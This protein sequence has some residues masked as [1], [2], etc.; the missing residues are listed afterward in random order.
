MAN[1]YWV[2]G[3]GTW[4]TT[5][6]TNWST[7][8]GGSGGASVPTAADSVF[9]D[10]AGTYTVTCS[11]A[12]KCL[13]FTVSAGSVTFSTGT[14]PAFNI[15][16]SLSF[17]LTTIWS[18]TGAITF[19]ATTTGKTITTNGVAFGSTTQLFFAGTGGYWTL[20][21]AITATS[22]TIS[23]SDGTFD[24]SASNYS[25]TAG[26]LYMSGGVTKLNASTITVSQAIPVN[27]TGGTLNAGTSSISCSST[28]AQFNGGGATFYNVAFT[29]TAALARTITGANT[30][31]NLS[32]T[33]KTSAGVSNI[34]IYDNQTINGTLTLSAG[35]NATARTFLLSDTFGTTRTLTCA[36]FSATDIDFQDITIAGAAAPASGTRLGD[37]KGNSGITFPAPKTVYKVSGTAW[38]T[39]SSWATS[40][41]GTGATNN[42]PLAQDTA[43]IDNFFPATGATFSVGTVTYAFGTVDLSSRTNAMTFAFG[44]NVSIYGNLISGTG[45]T[46]SGGVQLIFSGRNNQYITS[47]G[48]THGIY[49]TVNTITGTVSL[50]DALSLSSGGG[51]TGTIYLISGTFDAAGYNVTATSAS[52]QIQLNGSTTRSIN[53]GSGTWTIAGSGNPWLASVPTA[54]SVSGTGIISF[55]SSSAK[56]FQGGSV[57]YSGITIDQNGS[58][59]LTINGSNTLKDVTNTYSATGATTIKF[60]ALTT[61]TFSQFTATGASG[62]VLTLDSTTTT[63]A[64]LQKGSTWYMGANSTNVSNNTGLTF[65][66]GGGIDYLSVSNIKGVS[67]TPVTSTGNFFQFFPM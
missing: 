11:G 9:F 30:F 52:S 41:G 19:D 15:S 39:T 36:A 37:C 47:A 64:T 40:S 24:T 33:G 5:T 55:T 46:I 44:A 48:L 42:F 63:Q 51:S 58:G 43:V 10:Q 62:K 22:A 21:S 20:G 27:Y 61:N 26:R 4:D 54:L 1:R 32:V 23:V 45:S 29:S 67:T 66:A 35:G 14:T 38:N 50:Q 8:S 31:N 25:I 18:V 49:I 28:T 13:D 65:T 60:T 7:A 6:T 12:L 34:S 59:A 17:Y 16:G 56:T 2:G 3:A 57:N 53:V